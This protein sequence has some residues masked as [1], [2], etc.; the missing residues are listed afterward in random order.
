MDWS[1][2]LSGLLGAIVGG[3]FSL[4]GTL[5]TLRSK[6]KKDRRD[7]LEKINREKPRLEIASYRGFEQ[8]EKDLSMNNDLNVL[9]VGIL[10]FSES[11]GRVRFTY[12]K[13]AFDSKELVFVEY[14]LENTGLTEIMDMCVSSNLPK[15]MSVFEYERKDLYLKEQLLNYD[16][17]SNKRYI[18]P[19]GTIKLRIYYIRD[20][21]PS[22]LLGEHELIIWLRDI[23]GYTWVQTIN[24]PFNEIEISEI[25]SDVELKESIDIK[26]AIDCFRNPML[27]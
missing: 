4:V 13:K 27:W 16:A 23:N 25:S 9:A 10:G 26:K 2:L 11:G 15:T 1:T 24:A 6:N 3:G 7:K 12:D 22:S 19:K 14:L 20:Q 18:K 8:T 17:W 5:I 21:I